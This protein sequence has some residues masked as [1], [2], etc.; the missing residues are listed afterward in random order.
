[1]IADLRGFT[2]MTTVL[3]LEGLVQ[4]LNGW[5]ERASQVIL[6]NHGT[7]DKFMGDGVMVLF[8]APITKPDDCLRA[9]F[10]AFR[11]QEIFLEFLQEYAPL[12]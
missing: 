11:L 1:M 9:A 4:I 6:R 8:G 3:P 2:A 12:L 7:I 10:T 5:F